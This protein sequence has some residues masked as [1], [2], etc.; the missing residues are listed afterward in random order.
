M[1]K[2]NENKL[3]RPQ[4]AKLIS[5]ALFLQVSQFFHPLILP[6]YNPMKNKYDYNRYRQY[7]GNEF[8]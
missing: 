8:C 7:H 1:R 3:V 6:A 4:A 5:S 2:R